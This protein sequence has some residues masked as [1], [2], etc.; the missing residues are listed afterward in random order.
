MILEQDDECIIK[1]FLSHFSDGQMLLI[2]F[3]YQ[4]IFKLAF[5]IIYL[6]QLIYSFL[7]RTND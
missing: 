3:T 1:K 5:E 4:P 2:T 7:E 6:A